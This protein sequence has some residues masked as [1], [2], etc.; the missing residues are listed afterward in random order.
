MDVLV[1][2]PTFQHIRLYSLASCHQ[3]VRTN[4]VLGVEHI[5]VEDGKF[6][7]DPRRQVAGSHCRN[8]YVG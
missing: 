8:N 1:Q 3:V 5:T 2:V 6:P 7:G 4:E